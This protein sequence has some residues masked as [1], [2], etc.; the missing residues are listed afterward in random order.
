MTN[1]MAFYDGVTSSVDGGREMDVIYLEFSKAFNMVP[2]LILF[3]KLE[4][5]G[6]EG[7]T[8]R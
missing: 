4:R 8:V 6:F 7:W 3:P 2:Y 1:L 5:Y